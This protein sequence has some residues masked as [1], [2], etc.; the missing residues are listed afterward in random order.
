MK[1]EGLNINFDKKGQVIGK[2]YGKCPKCKK[3]GN[4]VYQK[5]G[6]WVCHRCRR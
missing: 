4:L 3:G 5:D 1:V 6:K 2:H